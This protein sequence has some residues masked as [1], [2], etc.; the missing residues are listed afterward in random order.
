MSDTTGLGPGSAL[1]VIDVQN[2]FCPG[3]ALAVP[4]GDAILPAINALIGAADLVVLTQDW[5]P[6]RHGSFASVH[7][8]RA[9]FE[10]ITVA[11]GP[12]TLW[13]DHCVQGTSGAAF[14]EELLTDRAALIVRKGMRPTVDSYS[15]FFENDRV[16]TTGLDG[17]LRSRGV[18]RVVCCGLAFDYCVAYSALDARRLG[19]SVAVV[20]DACAAIDLD[21]SRAAQA[22]AMQAAGVVLTTAAALGA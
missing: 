12:Q 9:P 8:G 1:L 13:P 10:T 21:G 22:A 4:G 16:T 6:R 20:E 14:H 3:G 2:D 19:F 15:A 7:K 18:S 11:Y 5:H 17:W